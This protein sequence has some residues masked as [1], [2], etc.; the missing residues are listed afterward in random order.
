[1]YLYSGQISRK[2]GKVMKEKQ[3]CDC[4]LRL[5]AASYMEKYQGRDYCNDCIKDARILKMNVKHELGSIK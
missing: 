1:M 5:K 3:V 2:G 4:C